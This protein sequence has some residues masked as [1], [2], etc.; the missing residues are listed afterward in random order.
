M[1]HFEK[2]RKVYEGPF[3]QR[4]SVNQVFYFIKLLIS[5]SFNKPGTCVQRQRIIDG[6]GLIRL[7]F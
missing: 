4:V 5:T 7:F 2:T 6:L 1:I 3:F